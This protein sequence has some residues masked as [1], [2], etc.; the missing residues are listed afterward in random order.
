M[1][2]TYK[3]DCNDLRNSKV[4]DLIELLKKTK[5]KITYN[6]I[7]ADKKIF[8]N[9]TNRNLTKFKKL[10]TKFDYVMLCQPHQFYIKNKKKI[11]SLQ[12]KSGVFFDLKNSFKIKN[13]LN[14][15]I[16]TL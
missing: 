11:L 5:F 4:I 6:D 1:G 15:K 2:V 14:Y 10:N 13:N 3:E 16:F 12:N 9:E 8:K 7:L